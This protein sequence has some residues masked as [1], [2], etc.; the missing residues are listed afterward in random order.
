MSE[1]YVRQEGRQGE[2]CEG[3]G[4]TS[5]TRTRACGCPGTG[6]VSHLVVIVFISELKLPFHCC[7]RMRLQTPI[8][9]RIRRIHYI[10]M[11]RPNTSYTPLRRV[12]VLC[13]RMF[14]A[15]ASLPSFNILCLRDV[16]SSSLIVGQCTSR[17]SCVSGCLLHT[18]DVLCAS[19]GLP[20]IHTSLAFA[21]SVKRLAEP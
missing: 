21:P 5:T 15:S 18:T 8:S 12:Y 13:R 1:C 16:S 10:S 17:S 6:R 2:D 19:P 11:V 3:G 9:P 4:T 20:L 7:C 14:C